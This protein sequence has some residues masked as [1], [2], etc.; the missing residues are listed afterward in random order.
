M[1]ISSATCLKMYQEDGS[2]RST[3]KSDLHKYIVKFP[4][5]AGPSGGT[6]SSF[7]LLLFYMRTLFFYLDCLNLHFLVGI[8]FNI[9]TQPTHPHQT[10]KR[11]IESRQCCEILIYIG[12]SWC[13]QEMDDCF[14]TWLSV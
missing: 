3:R 8:A 10:S 2:A 11:S 7:E 6:S 14:L 5:P 1:I 13:R 12:P 9:R 4:R